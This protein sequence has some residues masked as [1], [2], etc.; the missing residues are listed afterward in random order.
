MVNDDGYCCKNW[1]FVVMLILYFKVSRIKGKVLVL[2]KKEEQL[3]QS[4][5]IIIHVKLKNLC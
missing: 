3:S 5:S 2:K 1:G 4:A